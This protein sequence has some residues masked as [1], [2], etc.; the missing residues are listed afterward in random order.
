MATGAE[1]LYKEGFK[2]GTYRFMTKP[3]QKE[4]L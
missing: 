4:E 3:F 1:E 2:I